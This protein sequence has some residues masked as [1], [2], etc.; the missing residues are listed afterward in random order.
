MKF[1]NLHF[2]WILWLIP[3][4]VFFYI[5]ANQKKE[6][7]IA[8]FVSSELKDRLLE[9]VSARRTRYKMYFLILA[10]ILLTFALIRPKWGFHWEEI[11]RRGVDIMIALDV[12]QSMLAEDAAPNRLERAKREIIDLLRIV[13]GDR[14]GLIAFAGA[15][16]VQCPLT[17]DYGAVRIFLKDIS[18]NLIP[19]PG[20]AIG[21]SIEQ[22]VGAFDKEYKKSRA[23]ILITDGEDHAGKPI[24]AAEKAAEEGVRIYPIGIGK[25]GG[26]PIPEKEKGGFKKDRKGE[27]ILTQIDEGSLQKIAL[28][29]GGS[30]VR[31]VTGDLDL[32]KIYDDIHEKLEEKD[33]K[34]G[35]QKRFEE[36]FQWPLFF[37][38]LLLV[39]EPLISRNIHRGSANPLSSRGGFMVKIA[40]R[41]KLKNKSKELDVSGG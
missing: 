30:Y 9:N 11:K 38:F 40:E 33:L 3:G 20:T 2:L 14:V 28:A 25:E 17:L 21:Q 15:S 34:S 31:S 22:A 5:W 39:W 10:V 12:S 7:L 37:A 41:M 26:A 35:K 29:T 27:V 32:E 8:G 36:R 4:I 19:I 1:G 24:E 16:F 18:T 6:K 13:E 23:L